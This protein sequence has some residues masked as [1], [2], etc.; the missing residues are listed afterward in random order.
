ML[1]LQGVGASVLWS[2]TAARGRLHRSRN[3]R[4]LLDEEKA[5]DETP[6]MSLE[7]Y[8]PYGLDGD[9]SALGFS[10]RDHATRYGSVRSYVRRSTGST[11]AT[12]MLHGVAAD[13]STWAP[14]LR[15]AASV[16][17]DLGNLVMIDMPGY[18]ASENLLRTLWIPEVGSLYRDICDGLDFSDIRLVGHSMGGF[19]CLDMAARISGVTAV[20]VAAGSYFGILNTIKRPIR[21]I[22]V[23]PRTA[24]LW[25][26]YWAISHLGSVGY[27]VING[28]AGIG[29]ARQLASPFLASTG[30]VTSLQAQ[31]LLAQLNPQG[32]VRTARNGPDYDAESIWGS[33]EVPLYAAFGDSDPLVTS[34]DAKEL[35]RVNSSAHVE[36]VEG[37]SHMLN[38]ERPLATL[39][40]LMLDRDVESSR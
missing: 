39:R 18:G 31:D 26:A 23:N 13:S 33:I 3:T 17:V 21:N 20:H 7:E 34:W 16:G 4:R 24:V 28:F 10:T 29:L 12:L 22:R 27:S 40:A 15:A 30:E 8:C 5:M 35:L 6:D 9:L 14:M 11:I 37:A 38:V 36:I 2:A 32:V 25:N 19:L 1:Y